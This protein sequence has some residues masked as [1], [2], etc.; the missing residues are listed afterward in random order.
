MNRGLPMKNLVSFGALLVASVFL[1]LGCGDEVIDKLERERIAYEK[2][3]EIATDKGFDA[4][5]VP[6]P[7]VEKQ[8]GDWIYDFRDEAQN[9]WIVVIV[10]PN[11]FAEVSFTKIREYD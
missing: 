5:F 11:G 4:T 7:T 2:L 10:H 3:S 1:S 8:D 6:Q 9:A